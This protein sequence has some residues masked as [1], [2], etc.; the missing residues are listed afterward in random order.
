MITSKLTSKAQTTIPRAIRRAL[1]L[2]P[3]DQIAYE[4]GNDQVILTRAEMPGSLDGR[5]KAFEEWR[6]REDEEAYADL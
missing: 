6:G 1:K 5:L 2:E 3:G 4:I